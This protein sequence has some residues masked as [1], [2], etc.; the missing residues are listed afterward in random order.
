MFACARAE[1]TLRLPKTS[2]IF[3]L[4]ENSL[5]HRSNALG[6]ILYAPKQ[7]KSETPS[8]GERSVC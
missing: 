6:K 5:F 2:K 3:A 8:R 1:P 7:I 4:T